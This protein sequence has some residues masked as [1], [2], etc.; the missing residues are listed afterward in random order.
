MSDTQ[1]VIKNTIGKVFVRAFNEI[2]GADKT[3]DAGN[4]TCQTS[5]DGA[6]AAATN[7]VNPAE[8]DATDHPGLYA[9]TTTAAEVNGVTAHYTPVSATANIKLSPV[10]VSTIPLDLI[11]AEMVDVLT[12]D[13]HAQ[14]GQETPAAT[15]TAIKMLSFLYK[16]WR[17]KWD[18]NGSVSNLYNDD[19]ATVDQKQTTAEAAGTVTKGE[20]T[21]GP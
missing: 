11:N 16:G 5:L 20:I 10:T 3:G 6:A 13:T 1:I 12:V 9:F 15:Q 14:P 4:I 7:D 8:V 19:A 21:T 18:Q 2:T 17:N